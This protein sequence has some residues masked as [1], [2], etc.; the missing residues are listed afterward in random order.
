VI[1]F[2]FGN[3]FEGKEHM[4]A[5]TIGALALIAVIWSL[6]QLP[7]VHA[8][9]RVTLTLP[10]DGDALVEPP[11][12]THMW[13]A[14]PVNVRDLHESGDFQYWGLTPDGRGLRIV[15]QPDG[16]GVDIF[17]GHPDPPPA[18]EW[19][20]ER[21]VR[22][23]M[24]TPGEDGAAGQGEVDDDDQDILLLAL[25]TTGSI[26]GVAVLGL[27]LYLIR[28]RIGFWMHRPP[29]PE[30]EEAGEDH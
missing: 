20:F 22:D 18:G 24:L 12:I 17:P 1:L 28:Q 15:F 6:T 9:T 4:R 13:F 29:P 23:P 2:P 10:E 5:I 7:D 21:R 11:P 25:I 30:G 16:L 3:Q 14:S 26:A 27:F 8:Q 19:T